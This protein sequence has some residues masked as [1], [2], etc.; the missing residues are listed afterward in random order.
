M[1]LVLV[2]YKKLL[3]GT[4]EKPQNLDQ[5]KKLT[6]LFFM[7]YSRYPQVSH[8]GAIVKEYVLIIIC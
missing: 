5:L 4:N 1:L 7:K 3:I 2:R 6:K 8:V